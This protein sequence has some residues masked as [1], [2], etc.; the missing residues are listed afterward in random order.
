M[1]TYA[2][3][4]GRRAWETVPRVR[5][6]LES[7]R[8]TTLLVPAIGVQWL[9]TLALALIVRHNGFIYYQGGDQLWYYNSG[10]L[11]AHGLIPPAL[12]GHGL[13]AFL[14]PLTTFTGP[15]LAT[16][17]PAIV[18]FNV[19]VLAPIALLCMYGI[20]NEIGGRVF[21][22]WVTLLWLAVP[23]I[24]I[25]Y[26]DHLYH[27][28]YTELTLPQGFG[29]TGMADFPSMVAVL[30]S[31][32]FTLRV[33]RR[34][35]RVDALA[36]GLAAGT[37]IAIK[38]SN[39]VFIA[40]V[41][42]GLAYRRRLSGLALVGAGLAPAVLTLAL[43]KYRGFGYVPL[44]RSD[45]AV[46]IAVGP[47]LHGLVGLSNPLHKY[48]HFDWHHLNQANLLGIKEHFWSLRVIEW[49]VV[50]GLIGLARRS[51][52]MALVVGGWFAAFVVTKGTYQY[53]SVDDA[54]IFRIMM[55][56]YPA[57]VLLLGSLVFLVPRRRRE[58]AVP[59][60]VDS[61]PRNAR[62]PLWLL[63]AAA[64]IF[65]LYPFALVAAASPQRGPEPRAYAVVGLLRTI[66]PALRLSTSVDGPRVHLT[67]KN[68][69]P[70]G[71]DVFYRI[72]R[73]KA[74]NGG[75]TCTPVAHGAD[76]CE[77]VMQDIGARRN[78]RFDDAPGRGG[79]T[80]RLGLAANWLDSPL[81][82]DVYSLGPPV[83]VRVP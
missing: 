55:P 49:F 73:S 41:I 70:A 63:G 13:P 71:S 46:Q 60:P 65:A 72:L 67:W 44:F 83:V 42:L 77:L 39:S 58:P 35:D 33:I 57:F 19:A 5:A 54:S 21:G 11:L 66:D 20:A 50:A 1:T 12:V 74:P 3:E 23:F 30:V 24:G 76:D 51:I 80:Y 59:P 64:A 16:A 17:L 34:F 32:Y 52:T 14:A 25:K 2:V 29:L 7:A 81:Y 62:R 8:P 56:S 9:T 38:P 22:Y 27:Q 61:P 31:V 47:H 48:V 26:T 40:G 69:Q 4:A 10:W 37:A 78:G 45:G 79:W 53:A 18:L 68:A 6:W 43:W 15:S 75:A 82:G 28:R 36:A